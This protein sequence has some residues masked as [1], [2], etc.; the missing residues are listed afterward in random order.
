MGKKQ[1]AVDE[2]MRARYGPILIGPVHCRDDVALAAVSRDTS[3]RSYTPGGHLVDHV[4]LK[5]RAPA[6]WGWARRKEDAP[7]V[8][9][10]LERVFGVSA[11][12]A[13]EQGEKSCFCHELA[14][15]YSEKGG[16]LASV[17]MLCC[18]YYGSSGVMF[19]DER[20][21]RAPA[22]SAEDQRRVAAALWE[23]LL[24]EPGD[25][26]EYSD[27]MY[28]SGAGIWVKFGIRQGKPFMIEVDG[29]GE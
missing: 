6:V 8:R 3:E 10:R 27:K 4:D 1:T 18:D 15:V 5:K 20:S 21:T 26:P 9:G 23:L 28:H 19:E 29:S 11:L 7:W 25:V 17:V 16:G 2:M 12:P 13:D 14:V 24:E 22:I